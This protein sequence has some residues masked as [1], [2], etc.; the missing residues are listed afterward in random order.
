MANLNP[1][2][3]I[4]RTIDGSVFHTR[5]SPSKKQQNNFYEGKVKQITS[6][7]FVNNIKFLFC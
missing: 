4:V 7:N 6:Y 3:P 1:L 5:P 2:A